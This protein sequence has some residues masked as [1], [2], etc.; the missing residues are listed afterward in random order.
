MN[1]RPDRLN[2]VESESA[3]QVV[4]ISCQATRGCFGREAKLISVTNL[5]G[6][7]GHSGRRV[8]Y[9]CTTCRRVFLLR[10]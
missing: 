8:R 10:H 5:E 2:K 9:R 3:G 6:H 1:I 7:F 4:M